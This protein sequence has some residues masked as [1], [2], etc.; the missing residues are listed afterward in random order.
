MSSVFQGQPPRV[1]IMDYDTKETVYYEADRQDMHRFIPTGV[2]THLDIGCGQ[3]AFGKGLKQKFPRLESWGL[4]LSKTEGKIAKKNLDKAIIGTIE[5]NLKELPDGYFDVISFND[6]LEHLVDPYEVLCLLQPKLSPN[7][8]VV[9]SIPNVRFVRN[10]VN[11]LIKK[12]WTYENGGI[13]DRTHLRFFTYKT[14]RDMFEKCGYRVETLE[15]IS[16]IAKWK[17]TLLTLVSLGQLR[18]TTFIQYAVV[19]RPRR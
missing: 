1:S 16:Q 19:A 4:E 2:S 8:V 11:L 3:G 14:M 5:D 10:L 17:A 7:G 9:A 12:D 13:L 6:V 18:D 15:G